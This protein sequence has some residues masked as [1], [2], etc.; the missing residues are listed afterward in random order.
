ML[1]FST[2]GISLILL[3]LSLSLKTVLLALRVTLRAAEASVK[4]SR[5]V[6]GRVSSDLGIDVE[7]SGAARAVRGVKDT[8]QKTARTIKK[9]G[10]TAVKTVKTT[11]KAAKTTGKVAVKT[12]KTTAKVTKKA[13]ELSIKALKLTIRAIQMLINLLHAVIAFL[14]S[15]GV[16]GIVILIV[17]ALF[18]VAAIAGSLLSLHISSD[19]TGYVIGGDGQSIFGLPTGDI[20]GGLGVTQPGTIP[21]VTGT[22]G[23][24]TVVTPGN[25]SQLYS[26][27]QTMAEWYLSNVTTYS[28]PSVKWYNCP[29]LGKNVGDSCA[30]FASSYACSVSSVNIMQGSSGQWYQ[31]DT[32]TANALR[33]AGWVQYTVTEVGG[34]SGLLPGDILVSS[35]GNYL[36][37]LITSGY[38][39]CEV[40]LGPGQSF[41]WGKVQSKFPSSAITLTDVVKK[42]SAGNSFTYAGDGG[43]HYYG[44][45][46]RYTGGGS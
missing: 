6:V 40:Y 35:K 12:A 9:T 44:R 31:S 16:V 21:G 17:V 45:V 28:A 38:G 22:T 3:V 11:A 26:A 24:T 7:N 36:D 15:L 37:P 10:Q 1:I 8:A 19:G 14:L 39:H 43:Y 41:G 29:L 2:F 46:W 20:T 33:A 18:L 23:G 25:T 34:V 30:Y 32:A 27:C 5:Q 42:D 4:A 13:A